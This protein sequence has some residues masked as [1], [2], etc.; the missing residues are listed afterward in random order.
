MKCLVW[1]HLAESKE[2]E[3]EAGWDLEQCEED[4]G[5]EGDVETQ[6]PTKDVGNKAEKGDICFV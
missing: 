3:V 5:E 6:L 1:C 4:G 2:G